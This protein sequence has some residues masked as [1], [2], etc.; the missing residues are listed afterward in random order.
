MQEKQDVDLTFFNSK[1]DD[2]FIWPVMHVYD[3]M[4]RRPIPLSSSIDVSCLP[5]LETDTINVKSIIDHVETQY[6][7]K[8]PERLSMNSIAVFPVHAK[9]PWPS[10]IHHARQNIHWRAA[11]EASEELL[12]KFVSEQTVN[13]RV[14][15]EDTHTWEMSDRT[16][17]EILQNEFVSR[18]RVPM[19]D[20]GDE[21]KSTLQQ[22]LIATV[23]GFHDE[24]GT[25]SNE[26][27]EVLSRLIDFI[28]HP[29]PPPE[30]K[31]LREYLDYRIDDAAARPRI[32]KFVRL[33][34]DH[35]C[36]ANDLASF[37]K[38]K[39]DYVDNKVRYL[40]NTV[41]EVRKIYSLPSD[42]VA[43]V[44]TLA[45]QIEVEK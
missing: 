36:I 35:V 21:S 26:G 12:Q 39:R 33:C 19:P 1:D 23:R 4:P 25:M 27:A 32:S 18:L 24:D 2:S 20:R 22:A 17:I 7:V 11:V 43:K 14:W 42:D 28:R 29:P 44:V 41:E 9:L 37:D 38:E 31:N 10:S 6:A 16:T 5:D 30:F 15:Q 34:E 45:I 13:N 3:C 8:T 40:I